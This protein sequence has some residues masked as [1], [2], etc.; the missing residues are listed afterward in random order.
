MLLNPGTLYVVATPIGNLEDVTYRA[1]RVLGGVDLIAAEDTRRAAKLLARYALTTPRTSLHEH[2]EARKTDGLLARLERGETIALVSDAGTP[3]VSDPGARLVRAARERGLRVEALPGPSAVLAALV[4]SG[5]GGGPFTFAGFP[6]FRS[7][8]R[9]RWFA[10]LAREPRPFV[11]F[12]A[13][14]RIDASLRDL[15]AAAGER[16]IAVCRE[17]T[18]LHEESLV[19][20]VGDVRER[21]GKPRGEFTVVVEASPEAAPQGSA[22]GAPAAGAA[23]SGARATTATP[24]AGTPE[25][26]GGAE[27]ATP[28]GEAGTSDALAHAVGRLLEQGVSR[29]AAV[30]AVAARFGVPRREVYQAGLRAHAPSRD[31]AEPRSGDLTDAPP[32]GDGAEP[33]SGDGAEPRSDDLTDAP[34]SDDGAEPRSG[35]RA[36]P[37]SGDLT[38]APRSGDLT[39]APR[40]GGD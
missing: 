36:E 26:A 30:R 7:H 19:G 33:R 12:E 6:P 25:A 37:R 23:T 39:D 24:G 2:N 31:G 3:L 29:T 5:L 4:S 34:P 20:P 13:P 10:A 21:L 17:L 35:D 8:A 14:H 18:K 11:F 22:R 27:T 9:A 38:D 16:T 15:H 40:G 1:V 32:S 28:G